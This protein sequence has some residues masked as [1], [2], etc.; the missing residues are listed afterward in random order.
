M[1]PHIVLLGDSTLDNGAY[2]AGGPDV[3]AQVRAALPS[4]WR[5]VSVAIDGST[6]ADISPQ[7]AEVPRSA[8]H[9]I[10]SV[11]GN[12]ALLRADLLDTPVSSSGEA[13]GLL[14]A[15]ITDFGKAYRSMLDAC[16]ALGLPTVAFTIYDGRFES[17]AARAAARAAVGA[18]NDVISRAARERTVRVLE[19]RDLCNRPE[20]FA[21]PIEP[22]V[23]GGL[24]IAEAI[25]SAVQHLVN[26][27][28]P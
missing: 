8:T 23:L 7:L 25:V 24:R 2:T 16:V 6:T 10:V 21:N 27:K 9:L 28:K 22:S 14:D 13:L 5:A 11:G 18:F 12:N 4:G 3:L 15:A 20:H 26:A 1:L 19:L 17:D